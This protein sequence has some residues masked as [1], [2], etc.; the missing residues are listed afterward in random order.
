MMCNG[1]SRFYPIIPLFHYSTTPTIPTK[2]K[3]PISFYLVWLLAFMLS[4]TGCRHQSG[5]TKEAVAQTDPKVVA[6]IGDEAIMRQDLE[7][8]MKRLPPRRGE[9]YRGRVLDRLIRVRVFSEAAKRAGLDKDPE[10]Q[11]DLE[12]AQHEILARSF[13]ARH[14]DQQA[15]P[16]EKELNQFYLAQKKQFMI[17]EGVLMQHIVVKKK[18]EAEA[19]LGKLKEGASFEELARKR[20]IAPSWKSGGLCGWLFKGR[21]EPELEKVAFEL[22]KAAL[23]DVIET[24]KGFQI[25]KV[26]ERRDKREL[27]FEEAKAKISHTLLAKKKRQLIH[28]YYKEAKVKR[29]PTEAGV[30]AKV[31]DDALTGESLAPILAKVSEKERGAIR[32]RWIDYFIEKEVFSK[33]A[34]K[35]GLENDP[36]VAYELERRREEVLADA[37]A[38]QFIT[39]K[40]PISDRDI[41]GY[42]QAHLEEFQRPLRMRVRSIRVETRKE[43][44]EILEALHEGASFERL[45][46]K[47]S[48]H[49]AAPLAGNIGWF[50]KGEK[51]AALERAAS[52]LEKG[53][54]S[55]IVKTGAGYEILKLTNKKGGEVRPLE[56]VEKGI[57]I[58]LTQQRFERE[59]QHYYQEARVRIL[60]S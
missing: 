21:M 46:M 14:V 20:S 7:N 55:D 16:S 6:M 15:V 25:I 24:N 43:A 60:D 33:E 58:K 37:F 2:A 17:P 42:Y 19:I 23:S 31:G 47:E 18:E 40:Y 59:R 54:I 35:V 28:Q 22:D 10:T 38:K 9:G 48:I 53:Q 41:A 50:G 30:L 8:A 26:L 29:N 57:R 52:S 27:G 34:R 11:G 45:A 3:P 36:E 1:L 51:D 5:G 56:E 13:I 49:P 32:R 4:L 44:E 39:Q 12:R